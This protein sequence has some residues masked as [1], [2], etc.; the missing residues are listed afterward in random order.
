[1]ERER[2]SERNVQFVCLFMC[3]PLQWI[4]APYLSLPFVYNWVLPRNFSP[5][6]AAEIPQVFLWRRG[7][8]RRHGGWLAPDASAYGQANTSHTLL[9]R[10]VYLQTSGGC[11][12]CSRIN[13]C[14]ACCFL[15]AGFFTSGGGAL[16]RVFAPIPSPHSSAFAAVPSADARPINTTTPCYCVSSFCKHLRGVGHT[17]SKVEDERSRSFVQG[18]PRTR[19]P[20]T[21]LLRE[22]LL[23]ATDR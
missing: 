23:L 2:E 19:P 1:M 12:P 16:L 13:Q 10:C 17:L 20:V 4:L 9:L 3:N 14:V 15:L 11:L 21:G 5:K 22:K 8:V 6:K 18:M 7:A